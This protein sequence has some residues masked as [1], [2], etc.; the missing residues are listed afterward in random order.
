MTAGGTRGSEP[1][2]LAALRDREDL[3][4]ELIKRRAGQPRLHKAI[5][6]A[7]R[8]FLLGILQRQP[9]TAEL[10]APLLEAFLHGK[11]GGT[12]DRY[13]LVIKPWFAHADQAGLP[14]LPAPPIPFACWLAAAG[15]Q[16]LGKRGY[17]QTKARC[18]AIDG[19]SALIGAP[20]PT[21]HRAVKAYRE[22]ARR[23]KRYRRGRSRPLL[24]HE[25][26]V[27]AARP[28]GAPPSPEPAAPLPRGR[29]GGRPALLSP[30]TARRAHTATAGMLAVM[31]D[32]G[33]RYDDGREGQLGDVL[34]F[35]DAVDIGIFGSKTDRLLTGQTAQMP[36]AATAPFDRASGARAIVEV[37]LKGLERLSALP[38]DILSPLAERLGETAPGGDAAESAMA[39]WPDAV[40]AL[41]SPLYARGL[42]VHCLPYYGS[43]LWAPLT[44]DTDLS[45]TLSTG[46]FIRLMRRTLAEAGVP[47]AGMAAH[48]ARRGAAATLAHGG[49]PLPTLTRVLRHT[50]SRSTEP[51]VFRS[52]LV[53]ETAAAMR[54]ASRRSSGDGGGPPPPP[55][56]PSAAPAPR[57]RGRGRGRGA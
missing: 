43:W 39:T 8:T 19:L 22:M 37:V 25:I 52:V 16:G 47:T 26:P 24:G 21:E 29:G 12:W 38:P 40:R 23:T 54:D 20:S 44:A 13:V 27:V 31:H 2:S 28:D 7:T 17:S 57:G 46:E 35:P 51:Y 6:S 9:G 41:A 48:S 11:A 36:S 18:V 14:A 3:R 55:G 50:D 10:P 1:C 4:D 5:S 34:F 56:R 49:M 30:R 15:E 45:A 32:A 53:A 33:L 42:P